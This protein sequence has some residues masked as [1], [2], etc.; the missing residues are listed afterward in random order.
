MTTKTSKKRMS[1]AEFA[2]H[3]GVSR[4]A[5]SQWGK[6]GRIVL[7]AENRVDVAASDELLAQTR[8]N[9]GG[10][11]GNVQNGSPQPATASA[12]A[13]G[14]RRLRPETLT[15]ARTAEA[16]T[17]ARLLNLEYRRTV[18]ELCEVSSVRAAIDDCAIVTRRL[19][20][21]IPNRIASAI[22]A[23]FGVDAS[24]LYPLMQTEIERACNE[25]ADGAKALRETIGMTRQ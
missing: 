25:I 2:R 10:R 13:N 7:D 22:A 6:A 3:R 14:S 1:M 11:G 21:Q 23:T 20:E 4:A 8:N 5:V 24:K 17:K 18:G 15:Q 16:S 9:R 19:I 12:S